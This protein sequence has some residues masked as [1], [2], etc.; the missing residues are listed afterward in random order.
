MH[1]D[2]N[3]VYVEWLAAAPKGV[4]WDKAQEMYAMYQERRKEQAAAVATRL[5]G[6][7][8]LYIPAGTPIDFA[9]NDAIDKANNINMPVQFIFNDTSVIAYPGDSRQTVIGRY[10]NGGTNGN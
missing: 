1:P 7:D 6:R 2:R 4:R 8:T 10:R 5:L 3:E 9:C